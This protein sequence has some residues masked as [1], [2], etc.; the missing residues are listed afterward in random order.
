MSIQPKVARLVAAFVLLAGLALGCGSGYEVTEGGEDP[1][2][3]G[4]TI[5]TLTGVI[6]YEGEAYGTR[7]VVGLIDE[8]PMTAPPIRYYEVPNFDGVF[9][10]QYEFDLD[11]Y[12]EGKSFYLAAFLDVDQ[13]DVNLMMNS[14][15]DPM[16]LP[17]EGEAMTTIQAGV[18]V[19]NFVL[20]DPEDVDFWW[21]DDDTDE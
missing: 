4:K 1:T 12:V 8:W 10:V 15:V 13:N 3:L 17:D 19:R 7:L 14:E 20:L 18:N 11:Q 9:P 5:G 21:L 6:Q 2:D 16:D